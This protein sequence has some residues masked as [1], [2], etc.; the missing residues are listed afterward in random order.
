MENLIAIL[1]SITALIV[2]ISTLIK[3]MIEAKKNL[4]PNKVKS[5]S[6]INM[7]II[8]LLEEAKEYFRADRIQVYD[9]HN[10]GHFANGRSALKVSCTYEVVRNGIKNCQQELQ[11]IPLTFIAQFNDKLLKEKTLHVK[12]IEEIKD[13][14]PFTYQIKNNQGIKTFYDIILNNKQGDPIG[15]LAIQYNNQDIQISEEDEN[16]IFKFKLSIE[17]ELEKMIGGK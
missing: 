2:A 7:N 15:F 16:E 12:D 5:Q 8:K 4:I 3:N 13:S 9:Y 14:M 10:G 6:S 17:N 11:G 1:T